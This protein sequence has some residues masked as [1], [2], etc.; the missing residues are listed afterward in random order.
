MSIT[1]YSITNIRFDSS[2]NI[3]YKTGSSLIPAQSSGDNSQ[4]STETS[5]TIYELQKKAFSD[6]NTDLKAST[7]SDSGNTNL[8]SSMTDVYFKA[9]DRVIGYNQTNADYRIVFYNPK[10]GGID[11]TEYERL[12]K[13]RDFIKSRMDYI[14]NV[15]GTLS[16]EQN[17]IYA[18]GIYMNTLV[19]ILATSL[20][21][22]AFVHLK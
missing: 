16:H 8:P 11:T 7:I 14:N 18:N 21:Y 17:M 4:W 15:Q 5:K 6:L 3:I 9:L 2:G 1:Y 19:A 20:L 12:V 22:L 13:N 10:N